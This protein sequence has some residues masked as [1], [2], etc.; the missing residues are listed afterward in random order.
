MLG[1]YGKTV[2]LDE[3]QLG[4]R[5]FAV[6]WVEHH[7]LEFSMIEKVLKLGFYLQVKSRKSNTVDL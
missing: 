4:E 3:T 1:G 7:V 2:E 6:N 5:I